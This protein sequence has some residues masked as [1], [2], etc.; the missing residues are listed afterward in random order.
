MK[1][2]EDLRCTADMVDDPNLRDLIYAIRNKSWDILYNWF[3][4][5]QESLTF[6]DKMCEHIG[7]L[8]EYIKLDY[9]GLTQPSSNLNIAKHVG[10]IKSLNE[11]GF[12]S[13][14]F[15]KLKLNSEKHERS[16]ILVN[17]Y[18]GEV[19]GNLT[20]C[21][22]KKFNKVRGGT[23]DVSH[24]HKLYFIG[25]GRVDVK[26]ATLTSL[27][28]ILRYIDSRAFLKNN[29]SKTTISCLREPRFTEADF[30][31]MWEI[32]CGDDAQSRIQ[33]V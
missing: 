22:K 7:G 2:S 33:W 1:L 20:K 28:F 24:P 32:R 26:N 31:G 14:I 5:W 6:L 12:E 19:K 10:L 9:Q 13:S 17:G 18:F 29:K 27:R 8:V 4:M 21:E 25:M 11:N 3:P 16:D 23:L 15:P 30:M